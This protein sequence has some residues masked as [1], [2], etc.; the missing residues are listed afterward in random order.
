MNITRFFDREK[1][2]FSGNSSVDEAVAKKQHEESL[3]DSMGL[4]KDDVF[5]QGLKPPECVKLL[6]N[7]LQNLETEMKNVK[8]I[9]LT[10]KEWQIKGNEQLNDMNSAKTF[11]NEKFVEFE[12]EIKN[13]N[14]EIRSLKKEN[15]YL[16]KRL[17]E[18]DAV[19]DI[20]EQ[21]S[22][23]NCILIY[24][25]DKIDREDT[26]DLS[27]KVIEEHMNQKLKPE[28]ID[29]SQRLGNPKKSRN[30]KPRPIIVKYVRYNTRNNI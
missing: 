25:V 23:R 5:A 7:C 10:A 15:S 22:R 17:E 8:E 18:M 28:D 4:E 14:E 29:R 13:N 19:L 21:Y 27:I 12:K 30:A 20:H 1:K 2:E 16:T 11:I 3:N 9:S 24:G 26:D 6:L